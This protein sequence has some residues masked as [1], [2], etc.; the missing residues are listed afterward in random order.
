M[1]GSNIAG[2]FV[3]PVTRIAN[4]LE[5]LANGVAEHNR[6]SHL[7]NQLAWLAMRQHKE[8]GSWP[9]SDGEILVQVGTKVSTGIREQRR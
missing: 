6:Q 9:N 1:L 5:K 3:A 2:L 4:A 8:N 7:S